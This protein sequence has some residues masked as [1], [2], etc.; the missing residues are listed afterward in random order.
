MAVN[1]VGEI[2][3]GPDLDVPRL[4]LVRPTEAESAVQPPPVAA[5]PAGI[6]YPAQQVLA[7]LE[8][9]A[10]A[11]ALRVLL[12]AV[13]AVASWLGYVVIRDPNWLK[14]SAL[15]LWAVLIYIPVISLN[16]RAR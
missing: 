2:D 15:G 10:R 14:L 8:H 16:A 3:H 7:V 9:A 1:T 12:F 6:I 5:A 13:T 4:K 11:L